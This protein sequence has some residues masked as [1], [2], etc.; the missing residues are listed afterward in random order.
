VGMSS[1]LST[2]GVT[3]GFSWKQGVVVGIL[4]LLVGTAVGY[5]VAQNTAPQMTSSDSELDLRT[6]NTIDSTT[7]A[8]V[9][10]PVP[11]A[12][13]IPVADSL[14]AKNNLPS[15]NEPDK[16]VT[17][18][19]K[20]SVKEKPVGRKILIFPSRDEDSK[21]FTSFRGRSELIIV[22]NGPDWSKVL[23]TKGFPIWVSTPLVEKIGTSHVRVIANAVNARSTPDVKFSKVLAR[24]SKG[25]V[26]K[27]SRKQGEWIRVWSS[28]NVSAWAK[29]DQL[30][31]DG[32]VSSSVKTAI[33]KNSV[34]SDSM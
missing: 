32:V 24:F 18:L 7:P 2:I 28:I 26:L 23:S 10:K 11:G 13:D 27:I 15:Q 22:E 21:A 31:P 9:I 6:Q 19:K 16:A 17:P 33:E 12:S 3:M 20:N 34:P 14:S 29:S 5:F 8:S 4:A 25:D 1:K 30:V